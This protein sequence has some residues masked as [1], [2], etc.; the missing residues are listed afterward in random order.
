MPDSQ[1]PPHPTPTHD[2]T[3]MNLF[4]RTLLTALVLALSASRATAQQRLFAIVDYMHVPDSSSEK[5]YVALEK[6]WQQIHQRSVDAGNCLSWAVYRVENGGRNQFVTVQ[7]YD[8]PAKFMDPWGEPLEKLFKN[9]YT[10]AE[11]AIMDK[12]DAIRVLTRHELWE[13]EATAM[14]GGREPAGYN[15]VNFMKTTPGKVDAY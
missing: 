9:L 11:R 5:E 14:A 15:V 7:V 8:S 2:G 3:P 4:F 1:L 12:T 13:V 10:D 6:L